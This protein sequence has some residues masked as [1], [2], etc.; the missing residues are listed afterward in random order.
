MVVKELAVLLYGRHVAQ[1]TE[2]RGGQHTLTYLDDPGNTPLSL[3]MSISQKA[4]ANRAV[5]PFLDGLLPDREE[6]RRAMGREFGVSGNNPFALLRH[7]GLDCAGAVQFTEPNAIDEALARAGQLDPLTEKQ[8]GDRLSRINEGATRSWVAPAERWSLAGAQAKFA[9]HRSLDGTWAEAIGA[10]PTTHILKPGA[11]EYADHALNEHVS[12]TVAARLG[13][14]AARS[15]YHE[16]DG[17]PCIVVERYDRRRDT[18]KRVV[19]I[20]QEDL[21]QALSV[22]P[23]NK[24]ETDGGPGVAKILP[25][26]AVHAGREGLSRFA[27]YQAYNYVI[28]GTDAHA[29]NYSLLLVGS[30][31]RLAPMYDLA[32]AFPYEGMSNEIPMSIDGERRLGRISDRHWAAFAVRAGL[33]PD[34]LIDELRTLAARAPDAFA[35][36]FD[37]LAAQGVPVTDLRNR[38]MPALAR[39]CATVTGPPRVR[40]GR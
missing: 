36:V 22:A 5:Q 20:H 40:S 32:S 1:L 9:L 11:A 37:E 39:H 8:I 26:L 2:T 31:V 7:V 23:A 21:C 4:H 34:Q 30:T 16:F 38:L 33:E 12:M 15:S 14:P 25:L 24:Y 6:T 10:T 3:S 18:S 28:G 27:Q 17:H 19:R 29:K 13:V 35:E